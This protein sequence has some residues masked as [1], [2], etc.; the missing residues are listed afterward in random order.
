MLKQG[1]GGVGGETA[2][3]GWAGKQN[4]QGAELRL[5]SCMVYGI[6]PQSVCVSK[7]YC[8]GHCR[9][10]VASLHGVD[11]KPLQTLGYGVCVRQ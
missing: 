2:Q 7:L 10:T 4:L 8:I 1:V 6:K 11:L 9:N 5:V 3:R